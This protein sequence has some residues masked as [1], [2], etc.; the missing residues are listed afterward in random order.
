MKRI[1][2]IFTVILTLLMVAGCTADTTSK[3]Q[4]ENSSEYIL[5]EGG[6]KLI[7]AIQ[8]KK[9]M[10]EQ[11][12]Y[13]ILDVRTDTEYNE[14]HI[15]NSVLLPDYTIE[16]KAEEVMPDKDAMILVYCR[17]GRRSANAAEKLAEMGYN[18][19]YDFG[20]IIDWPYGTV[21]Y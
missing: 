3:A 19:V 1:L 21:K 18:N 2:F 17:S 4:T 10:D 20:G 12:N 9:I 6:Y 16:D 7:T 15:E 8:A 5:K 11:T 13:I 14:G